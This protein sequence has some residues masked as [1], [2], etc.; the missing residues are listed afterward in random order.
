MLE[1][2]L[3][4]AGSAENQVCDVKDFYKNYLFLQ[5]GSWQGD[6]DNV[7]CII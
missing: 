3:Q 6:D 5:V 1:E 2:S 4:A 7:S